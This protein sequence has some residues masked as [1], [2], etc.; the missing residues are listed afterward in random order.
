M[1][2]NVEIKRFSNG[3]WNTIYPKANWNNMDNKPSTFTPSA[4]DHD[5]AYAKLGSHNNLTASGNEFTF[6]SSGFNGSMYINWRTA[7]GTNGNI[8][9]Y[10]LGKGNGSVLGTIIHS[11][12]ISDFA[13]TSHQDISGKQNVFHTTGGTAPS[14]PSA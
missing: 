1:A 3:A 10:I 6:A 11:G 2:T 8:T 7:G 14:N 13:I 9:E 5:N 4:H 12:N